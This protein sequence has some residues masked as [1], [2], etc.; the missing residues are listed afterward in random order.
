MSRKASGIK[1]KGFKFHKYFNPMFLFNLCWFCSA[2]IVRQTLNKYKIK[3]I[4]GSIS[5]L[6][7]ILFILY[8]SHA[9]AG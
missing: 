1:R 6:S 2:F 9:I 5:V 7:H 3:I 8:F 4:V